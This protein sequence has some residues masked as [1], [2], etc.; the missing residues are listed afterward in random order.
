MLRKCNCNFDE[1]GHCA[2]RFRLEKIKN[3]QSQPFYIVVYGISRHYGGPEEGGWY[4]DR[5]EALEVQKIWTISKALKIIRKLKEDYYPTSKYN[6]YSVLGN[7]QDIEIS[8]IP[9]LDFVHEVLYKEPW[10]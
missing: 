6:R 5:I 10:S 7:G 1:C 2:R 8:L 9:N 3:N 4:W